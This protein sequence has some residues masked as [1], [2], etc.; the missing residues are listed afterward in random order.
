MQ[1][2]R[3]ADYAVRA[4]LHMSTLPFGSR[5]SLAVLAD[6]TGVPGTFL[7]KVLQAL[8]RAELVES[9]RGPEGGFELRQP[10]AEITLLTVIEAIDGPVRLNACLGHDDGCERSSWCAAHPVWVEAQQAMAGVLSRATIAELAK[11]TTPRKGS[12]RKRHLTGG[13]GPSVRKH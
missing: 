12:L 7:S 5:V 10:P 13:A 1:L 4:M 6:A 3:A 2:T 8:S 11:Q 9:R